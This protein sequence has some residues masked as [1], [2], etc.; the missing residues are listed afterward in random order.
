MKASLDAD[1]DPSLPDGTNFFAP[2]S[3]FMSLQPHAVSGSL[4]GKNPLPEE[5][6]GSLAPSAEAISQNR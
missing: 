5:V 4:A 2:H 1:F 6:F 3:V